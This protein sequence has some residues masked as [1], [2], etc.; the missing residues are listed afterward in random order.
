MFF[1]SFFFCLAD[2]SFSSA[3]ERS[4]YISNKVDITKN[5]E[6]GEY[7]YTY[8]LYGTGGF[9][10]NS[11]VL[12]KEMADDTAYIITINRSGVPIYIKPTSNNEMWSYWDN[13]SNFVTTAKEGGGDGCRASLYNKTTKTWS[14]LKDY[15]G[16]GY[17]LDHFMHPNYVLECSGVN[18]YYVTNLQGRDVFGWKFIKKSYSLL[19]PPVMFTYPEVEYVENVGFRVYMDTFYNFDYS[20][21][22]ASIVSDFFGLAYWYYDESGNHQYGNYTDVFESISVQDDGEGLYYFDLKF[23]EHLPLEF[24]TSGKTYRILFYFDN[25]TIYHHKEFEGFGEPY[26]NL[27][28]LFR[29]PIYFRFNSST[30][31]DLVDKDGNKIENKPV[32]PV[33][34]SS[35]E[36]PKTPDPLQDA[37][38]EQTNAI[39][40]NTEVQKNIFQQIIELPRQDCGNA[41]RRY[42]VYI[43]T[44]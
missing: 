11:F 16:V 2:C 24:K 6:T 37:L 39:K 31:L 15:T 10:Y 38:N 19:K 25:S 36:V 35:P 22:I 23:G 14:E 43:Y 30:G 4:D 5:E 26:T 17:S 3:A 33:P 41:C 13:S 8:E 27:K 9:Q 21:D 34:S 29:V 28:T 20:D 7:T 18:L 42:K 1:I 12:P 44:T 40:E 32:E